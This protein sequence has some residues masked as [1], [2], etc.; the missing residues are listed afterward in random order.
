MLRGSVTALRQK[1]LPER[2]RVIHASSSAEETPRE[3]RWWPLLLLLSAQL[4]LYTGVGAVLPSI[5]IYASEI[6]L[7][8]ST[9]GIVIAAP[10]AALVAVSRPAGGAA[11]SSRKVSMVSG[12]ALI[13]AADFATAMASSLPSLVVARLALGVGRGVSEA[14]E[15][16]MLADLA[17]RIPSMRGRAVAAQQTVAALGI[18]AGSRLGGVVIELYGIRATFLCVTAAALLTLLLYLPL[19]ETSNRQQLPIDIDDEEL[20]RKLWRSLLAD[21]RWRRLCACE[22]GARFGY[23]A[24][25]AS[26]PLL[27][28][29]AFD[30]SP[31]AAGLVL[32]T[33]ALAGLAAAPLGGIWID[34]NDPRRVAFLSGIASACALL[35]VPLTFCAPDVQ[36]TR[37][38]FVALIAFW[39]AAVAVQVCRAP[40]CALDLQ[41]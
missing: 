41:L 6:G 29:R 26:V 19:P 21:A 13:A 30:G 31:A 16:G 38:T 20:S 1:W 37:F 22:C 25:L 35:L 14:G 23:A 9:A 36:T 28:V 4:T 5:P 34:R 40:C 27:A 33:A 3:H 10:A 17:S 24:K 32:S 8:S 2:G 7:S 11:D 15:R 18:A 39:S 12:M